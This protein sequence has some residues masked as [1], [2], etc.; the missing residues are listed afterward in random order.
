LKWSGVALL[1]VLLVIYR[2][3]VK[4]EIVWINP[5]NWSI[6]G[7]IG[8]AYLSVCILYLLA[9]GRVWMLVLSFILLVLLNTLAKLGVADFIKSIPLFLWPFGNGS[10][11]SITMAGA[12]LSKIFLGSNYAPQLK[13]KVLISSAF[14]LSILLAGWLLLPL[15]LAKIGSTPSWCLIS[16]GICIFVFLILYIVVD[17][18]GYSSW[19]QFVR[20][21]GSNPLLTYILPDIYYAIFGLHHFG[22]IAGAGLPGVMRAFLFTLFILGLSAIMTRYKIRLQL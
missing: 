3:N 11:A 14:G 15:G 9:K 13:D 16:A 17:F 10:L 12:I 5:R 18:K 7:G 1:L 8:W 6:L 4:G 20:P 2:R 21:A 19:A 22:T